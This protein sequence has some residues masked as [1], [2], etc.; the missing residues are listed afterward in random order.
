MHFYQGK[1]YFFPPLVLFSF[2]LCFFVSLIYIFFFSL[3]L[4]PLFTFTFFFHCH[5][6]VSFHHPPLSIVPPYSSIWPIQFLPIRSCLSNNVSFFFFFF[7]FRRVV[8]PALQLTVNRIVGGIITFHFK[9][10]QICSPSLCPRSPHTRRSL[11]DARHP[12]GRDRPHVPSANPLWA[13]PGAAPL[14]SGGGG[15]GAAPGRGSAA[16]QGRAGQREPPLPLPPPSD[17][18]AP[19]APALPSH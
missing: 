19:H 16:G 6:L 1:Y 17:A 5:R 18:A 11:A 12:R 14:G 13:A 15:A 3:L 9:A 2:S 4:S 7:F 10:R 8:L